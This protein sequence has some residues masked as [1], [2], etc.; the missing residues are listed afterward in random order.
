MAK[1]RYRKVSTQIWND[2]KFRGMSDDGQMVFL[3]LLTHPHMTSLGAMRAT[4]PGLAA[5]KG[6]TT[7]RLSEGFR[8]GCSRGIGR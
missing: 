3:F 7:E 5:E 4:I 8:E 6:W 2:E 1:H